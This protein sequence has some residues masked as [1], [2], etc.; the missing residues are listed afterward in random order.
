[1]SSEIAI[2]IDNAFNQA[3]LSAEEYFDE[4]YKYLHEKFGEN[5]ID[6]A[7]ELA[8]IMAQDFHTIMICAKLQEIRDAIGIRND[9]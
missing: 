6:C 9:R 2:T 5:K 3:K 1:M 7:I 8:K 4:A